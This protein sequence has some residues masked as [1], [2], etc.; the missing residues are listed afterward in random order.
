M[1]LVCHSGETW[2]TNGINAHTF[3]RQIVPPTAVHNAEGTAHATT[4]RMQRVHV[5]VDETKGGQSQHKY[6]F[7][8]PCKRN[9]PF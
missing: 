2:A 9:F 4:A 1:K 6:P 5:A 7:V 8:C 3:Y